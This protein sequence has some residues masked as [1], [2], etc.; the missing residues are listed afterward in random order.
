[1]IFNLWVRLL[2]TNKEHELTFWSV[3]AFPLT[4]HITE[5]LNFHSYY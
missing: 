4:I 1:V 2:S 5:C 3:V